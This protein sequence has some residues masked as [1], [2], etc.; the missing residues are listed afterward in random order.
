MLS[1]KR[2]RAMVGE[3][4]LRERPSAGRGFDPFRQM[5]RAQADLNRLFGALRFYPATEFP[6]MNL[7]TGPEGAILAVEVPGVAPEN[8]DITNRRDTVTVRGT[9]PSEPTEED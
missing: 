3:M 6:P 5:Q 8:L 4:T 2:R 1:D 7:W 9:R